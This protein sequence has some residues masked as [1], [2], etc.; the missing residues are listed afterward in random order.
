LCGDPDTP[1][2]ALCHDRN[3]QICNR[4]QILRP[5]GPFDQ[6]DFAGIEVIP[7]ACFK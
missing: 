5:L 6:A 4:Q 1:S 2:A 3:A 7:E